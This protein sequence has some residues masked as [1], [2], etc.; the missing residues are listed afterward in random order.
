MITARIS[1]YRSNLSTFHNRVLSDHEPLRIIGPSR[2]D[3]VILAAEDFQ[4][5]QESITVLKD[6]ATLNSLFEGRSAFPE[7]AGKGSSDI[8]DVFTDVMDDKHK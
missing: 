3:I 8:K 7:P 1:E 2:G 4:R 5:L 6:R